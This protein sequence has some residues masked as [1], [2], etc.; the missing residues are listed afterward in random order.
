MWYQST[1]VSGWNLIFTYS[2]F[3]FIKIDILIVF[4][5]ESYD[6]KIEQRNTL[7]KAIIWCYNCTS[8]IMTKWCINIKCKDEVNMDILYRRVNNADAWDDTLERYIFFLAAVLHS[9][10]RSRRKFQLLEPSPFLGDSV[11]TN[12][13]CSYQIH[14]FD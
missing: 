1:V 13:S 9:S 14:Q 2:N 10:I 7:K 11:Y 12:F 3:S 4:V 8:C 6:L 5:L